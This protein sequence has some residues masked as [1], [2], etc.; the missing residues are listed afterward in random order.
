MRSD[1]ENPALF[2][3]TTSKAKKISEEGIAALYRRGHVQTQCDRRSDRREI[4]LEDG[5]AAVKLGRSLGPSAGRRHCGFQRRVSIRTEAC[6][7]GQ[8]SEGSFA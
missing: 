7:L 3:D 4:A 6:G 2:A 5:G 8:A 1:T